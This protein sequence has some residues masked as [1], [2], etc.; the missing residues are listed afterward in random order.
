MCAFESEVKLEL[1]VYFIHNEE[2]EDV[3]W[4]CLFLKR[5]YPKISRIGLF[6][7]EVK[8]GEA[9]TISLVIL[10]ARQMN[11]VKVKGNQSPLPKI[12]CISRTPYLFIDVDLHVI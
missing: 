6:L 8:V 1:Y 11:I 3:Y 12:I 4:I 5:L 2:S 10:M 7:Q 9:F